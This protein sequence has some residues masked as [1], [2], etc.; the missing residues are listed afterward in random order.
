MNE[1]DSEYAHIGISDTLAEP[2]PDTAVRGTYAVRV[3][4][5]ADHGDIVY[6]LCLAC[7]DL[8]DR[9]VGAAGAFPIL[10]NTFDDL[11][12]EVAGMMET[13]YL[14]GRAQGLI[15]EVDG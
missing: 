8:D 12:R 1:D 6:Q 9:F 11:C 15:A 4:T 7:Y 5:C 3:N 2:I 10:G 14:Y 13:L